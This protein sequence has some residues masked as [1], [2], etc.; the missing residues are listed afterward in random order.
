[1]VKG[2]Y[3]TDPCIKVYKCAIAGLLIGLTTGAVV[4]I[5]LAA[6]LAAALCGGGTYAATTAFSAEPTSSVEVNPLYTPSVTNGENPLFGTND[7]AP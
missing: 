3:L 5:I 6:I 1:M 4:G 7:N 2:K